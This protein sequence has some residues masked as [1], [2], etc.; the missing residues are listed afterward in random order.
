MNYQTAKQMV[1][2]AAVK[3]DIEKRKQVKKVLPV[4]ARIAQVCQGEAKRLSSAQSG[5]PT[6]LKR[7]I[8]RALPSLQRALA[9]YVRV[10]GTGSDTKM[11]QDIISLLKNCIKWIGRNTKLA[12]KEIRYAISGLNSFANETNALIRSYRDMWRL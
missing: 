4:L 3:N 11:L 12:L 10:E 9:Q 2:K 5:D 7:V 8:E 6:Q 1:L